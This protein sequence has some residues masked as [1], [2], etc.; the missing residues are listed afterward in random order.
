[1]KT[2][3]INLLITILCGMSAAAQTR[4]NFTGV[5]N[6]GAGLQTN[7]IVQIIN[8]NNRITTIGKINTDG[9]FLVDS[10]NTGLFYIYAI[11]DPKSGSAYLPTYY[12]EYL[13]MNEATMIPSSGNVSG[14]NINLIQRTA[15][16]NGAALLEGRFS[17]ADFSSD[18]NTELS[19]N[20][21]DNTY[22][23]TAPINIFQPPCKNM[24][25]LLYNSSNQIVAHSV[26]DLQGYYSF[27]NLNGGN[28]RIQ[29]Q[30]YSYSTEFGGYI[31]V[32]ASGTT[33]TSLR[34]VNG[35]VT[36]IDE[37]EKEINQSIS[38]PNPF[39]SSLNISRM[40]GIVTITDLLGIVYF[41][42]A[43][44]E[45]AE[46]QTENWP[47]GVYLIK[48]AGSISKILKN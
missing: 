16:E 14:I 3:I 36:G 27:K 38:Y 29:G 12:L 13:T 32:S 5:I 33:Q 1:M 48:C 22:T 10:T 39:Q 25:V 21:L 7:G 45:G 28:Y 2:R 11:P 17:Y 20:W 15:S 6:R 23:P 41:E 37:T 35:A 24:S 31:N 4:I 42:N 46:I 47:K 18:D 43:F 44:F 8:L 9:T 30:R 34:M 26:T 19:R 40:K